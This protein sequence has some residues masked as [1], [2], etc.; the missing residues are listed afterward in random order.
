MTTVSPEAARRAVIQLYREMV[1]ASR[2]F[3]HN[4]ANGN[5]WCVNREFFRLIIVG[6]KCYCRAH[7]KK[8]NQI[9]I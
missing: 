4:D 5:P 9:R 7:E 6:E 8:S 1:R 2:L 3:V